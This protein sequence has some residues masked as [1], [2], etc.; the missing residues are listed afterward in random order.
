[1]NAIERRDTGIAETQ[2][3][4]RI[5]TS[6]ALLLGRRPWNALDEQGATPEFTTGDAEGSS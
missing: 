5:W 3:R 4:Y 2:I 6:I 1:M